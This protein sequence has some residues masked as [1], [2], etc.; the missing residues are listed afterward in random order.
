MKA[1]NQSVSNLLMGLFGLLALSSCS[2]SEVRPGVNKVNDALIQYSPHAPEQVAQAIHRVMQ[3]MN[4][5]PESE[6]EKKGRYTIRARDRQ[7][8]LYVFTVTPVSSTAT[9]YTIHIKPGEDENARILLANKI[10][11][12]L[13]KTINKR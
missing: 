11:H 2:S 7:G 10:R 5:I 12:T 9:E 3:A 1:A 13:E 4:Y 6:S 8:T